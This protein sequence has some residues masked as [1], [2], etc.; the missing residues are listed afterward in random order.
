MTRRPKRH[1]LT[2]TTSIGTTVEVEYTHEDDDLVRITSYRRRYPGDDR[3]RNRMKHMVGK[4]CTL[5]Q[6]TGKGE[7]CP[8][9]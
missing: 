6:L 2:R 1:T 8:T 7:K 9:T 5:T 4:R 3:Y